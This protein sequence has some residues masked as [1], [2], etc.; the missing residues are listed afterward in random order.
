M[1][2]QNPLLEKDIQDRIRKARHVQPQDEKKRKPLLY[3]LLI[4][5]MTIAV[6]FSLFGQIASLF[7]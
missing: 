7:K 4:L 6:L 3:W 5:L 1:A 2:K